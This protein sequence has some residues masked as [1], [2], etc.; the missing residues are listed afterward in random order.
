MTPGVGELKGIHCAPS[1]LE[2]MNRAGAMAFLMSILLIRALE[3]GG[4]AFTGSL[5]RDSIPQGSG[6]RVRRK[7]FLELEKQVWSEYHDGFPKKVRG[8]V[9]RRRFD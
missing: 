7:G 9:F 8:N 6:A 2:K 4:Q 1:A 5:P 3:A